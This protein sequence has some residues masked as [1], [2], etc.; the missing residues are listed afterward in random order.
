M[1]I[2]IDFPTAF[3]PRTI[4]K[5]AIPASMVR[6]G[7]LVKHNCG[8]YFQSIPVDPYTNVAA[9][10]YD[11]AADLGYFKIDFLHLSCL[12]VVKD[13]TELRT[14][15]KKEPDWDMLQDQAVVERLLHIGKH[16]DLLQTMKPTSVQELADVLAIIRPGKRKLLAEYMRNKA[17]TRDKLYEKIE[18]SYAF[19]RGHAIS[20]ALTIIL[21]LHLIAQGRL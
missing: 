21:Q 16:A 2:D 20:Y 18:G 15:C 13:K 12:D 17:K 5:Q 4:M 14:L 3:D 6:N 11:Q 8:H 9:I 7:E 10:P 1:D 19:K